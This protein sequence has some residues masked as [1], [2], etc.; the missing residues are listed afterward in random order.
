MGSGVRSACALLLPEPY[1]RVSAHTALYPI[2][3][4]SH[5]NVVVAGCDGVACFTPGNVRIPLRIPPPELRLRTCDQP[6]QCFT[7]AV[8]VLRYSVEK[9]SFGFPCFWWTVVGLHQ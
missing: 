7:N 2:L 8:T 5:C 4:Y 6:A 1:V 9:P 3:A